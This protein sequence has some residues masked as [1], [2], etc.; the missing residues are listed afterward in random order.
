MLP[1]GDECNSSLVKESSS[2]EPSS[3]NLI[4]PDYNVIG[5]RHPTRLK[6]NNLHNINFLT[7][8][9]NN[10][11]SLQ[12]HFI[13]IVTNSFTRKEESHKDLMKGNSKD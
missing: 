1:D 12:N 7:N 6:T 2:D 5:H 10:L 11:N 13:N 4:L 8:Q 9:E 3:S